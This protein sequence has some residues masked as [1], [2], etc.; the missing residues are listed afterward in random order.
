M[1]GEVELIAAL[2]ERLGAAAVPEKGS[3]LVIG[4]GDDAAVTEVRGAVAT[5]VDAVIEG[6]HFERSTSPLRSVGH[7]ALAGALSDL[8]A[9]G[10]EPGEAYVQ[11]GL[12]KGPSE[13][14][15]L[16]LADGIADVATD[17]GLVIAGGDVTRAPVLLLAVT[18][19]GYAPSPEELVL[20]SGARPGD[21]L[22]VTGELGGA[23]GGLLVLSRPEL[24]G[25]VSE[26]VAD[27]LRRRQ[28]RPQPQIEAGRTL[29]RTGAKAMIDLSDGLGGD[30]RHLAEAGGVGARIEL[31]SVPLA[32][33]VEAVAAAA[34]VE[35]FE[36]ATGGGEDYELL[37]ALAPDALS[38]AIGA[39]DAIGV[40]LTR[41]GEVT[42]GSGVELIDPS[43]NSRPARGFDQLAPRQSRSGRGEAGAA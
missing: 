36:L 31:G 42:A 28:L 29:A 16:E 9:M 23:A 39:L 34:G 24:A 27:E 2:R 10:A 12:P 32:A 5:T 15:C 20:R 6:V 22:A 43:G 30:A 8:A 21:V 19:V 4:S 14:E 18:A 41:V 3:R 11:L 33:G 26:P 7:K 13:A 25:A 38:S 40:S 37:A 35:R 17:H 1:K